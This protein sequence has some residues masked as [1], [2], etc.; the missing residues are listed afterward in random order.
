MN[1]RKVLS[2]KYWPIM[3]QAQ[4]KKALLKEKVGDFPTTEEN[5]AAMRDI[6]K[7]CET[8]EEA[9]GKLDGF[10]EA[11]GLSWDMLEEQYND[12]CPYG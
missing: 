12:I 3:T 6:V 2:L 4:K 10:L 11:H 9:F 1:V 7:Q 5:I 8:A